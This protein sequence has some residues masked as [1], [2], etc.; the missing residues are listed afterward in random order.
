MVELRAFAVDCRVS[1]RVEIGESR[2]TDVLNATPQIHFLDARLEA[3]VDGHAV[4]IPELDAEPDEIC[5]VIAAGPRG[6][7]ARRVHTHAI[8]IEA[9]LGPYHV[10]GAVHATSASDPFG[11]SLRRAPWVPLTEATV[12]YQ[13][14]GR[15]V[16]EEI[17]TLIVNRP[18]ATKFRPIDAEDIVLPWEAPR[19][20]R[21]TGGHPLELTDL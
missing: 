7:P 13:E 16:R 5:A 15:L 14:A 17:E 11:A 12:E 18:L 8:R 10:E 6:D 2:V 19:P 3:L 9:D 1:G 4:G 21:P 20:A